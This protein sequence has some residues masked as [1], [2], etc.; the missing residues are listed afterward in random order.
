MTRAVSPILGTLLLTAITVLLVAVL[1]STLGAASLGGVVA[2]PDAGDATNFVRL[3]ATATA[4]GE[5]TLT[6]E[7]G[8]SVDLS[9]ASVHITVDGT[10]LAEQPPVPFFSTAGFEPGPTGPFNSAADSTW[11]VGEQASLTISGSN[12]PSLAVGDTVRVEL[13]RDGRPLG[14]VSSSVLGDDADGDDGEV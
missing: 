6:H 4:D 3:S 11:S 8:D 5:I 14:S 10:P 7:G 12:E 1:V 13:V 2:G 9:H